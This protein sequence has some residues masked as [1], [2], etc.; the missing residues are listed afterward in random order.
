MILLVISMMMNKKEKKII[1][2]MIKIKINIK[3]IFYQQHLQ[4]N[5]NHLLQI[6]LINQMDVQLQQLHQH[7][8]SH[9]ILWIELIHVNRN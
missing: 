5:I 9:Q 2:I 6:K 8:Q 1:I 3:M 7:Q 4:I